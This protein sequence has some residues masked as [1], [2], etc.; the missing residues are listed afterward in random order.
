MKRVVQF[1]FLIIA[2]IQVGCTSQRQVVVVS[3]V[4]NK[5][6]TQI[7]TIANETIFNDSNFNSAH[8]GICIY[9]PETKEYLY[10]Y[11]GDKYFVPASN[12]KLFTCYVAMKNLGDS[13][14][15]FSY[16][17][18]NDTLYIK[19]NADASLLHDDY[20]SDAFLN[21]I[22][23]KTIN[24]IVIDDRNWKDNGFGKGWAWDDYSSD[25]MTERSPLPMYGNL[26]T[27]SF[28]NDKIDTKPQL[29]VSFTNINTHKA[30]SVK[31]L[32][33][34]NKYTFIPADK[35]PKAIQLPFI[36]NGT[37]VAQKILL[38]LTDKVA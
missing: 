32:F 16:A 4:G 38:S 29:G 33:T 10:N 25:Y 5:Q 36:T 1:I 21:I 26:L 9:N 31:R 12:M 30:F 3:G 7:A 22:N 24:A 27:F 20:K 6:E 2:V 14:V 28:N 34:D 8:I 17:I 37:Q 15:G 18:S 23:D 19:G 11:Q 35:T 13:L